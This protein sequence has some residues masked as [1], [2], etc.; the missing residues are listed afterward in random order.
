MKLSRG[1]GLEVHL[2]SKP[3]D[4]PTPPADATRGIVH[5]LNSTDF[6]SDEMLKGFRWEDLPVSYDFRPLPQVIPHRPDGTVADFDQLANASE[7]GKVAW[8]V[9]D[10]RGQSRKVVQGR[11]WR[12]CDNFADVYVERIGTALL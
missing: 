2:V 11:A 3:I 8:C 12:Q 4:K 5:R 9:A 10:G 7:G 1:F 6:L